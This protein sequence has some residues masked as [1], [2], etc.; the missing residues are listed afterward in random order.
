DPVTNTWTTDA[1][2]PTSRFYLAAVTDSNGKMYA[3]GGISFDGVANASISRATVEVG[4]IVPD[5]QPPTVDANGPY[6]VSEGGTVQ[7]SATGNDPENG[8][9]TYAWDLDNNGSFET[10]GQTVTFSAAGLY[11]LSSHTITV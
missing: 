10:P 8:S 1:S 2:L 9:L 7:V 5:N 11:A 4:T 6:S 3:I